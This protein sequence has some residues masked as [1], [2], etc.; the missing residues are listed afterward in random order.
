MP[1]PPRLFHRRLRPLVGLVAAAC[2]LAAPVSAH[3]ACPTSQA[4]AAFGDTNSYTLSENGSLE[5]GST[6][7]RLTGGATVVNDA[8]PLGLLSAYTKKKS[9]DTH[10]LAL[11]AGATAQTIVTCIKDLQ[12]PLRFAMVNTGAPTS[13][14]MVSALTGS[15]NAPTATPIGALTGTS[16]WQPSPPLAF[17]VP[18][19]AMGFQFSVV[20]DGGRWQID[21]VLVDPF[22]LR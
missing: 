12:P 13:M 19:G 15:I 17:M 16:T 18:R 2:G 9:A 7:W 10:S 6:A 11:P 4:F 21:D 20:G 3:A 1:T 5:S 8:D 14:L 22:K